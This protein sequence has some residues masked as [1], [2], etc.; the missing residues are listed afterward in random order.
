MNVEV[1][2]ENLNMETLNL[3]IDA[4]V[5]ITKLPPDMAKTIAERAL[6]ELA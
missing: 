4:L 1:G 2:E 6:S 5:A 3:L